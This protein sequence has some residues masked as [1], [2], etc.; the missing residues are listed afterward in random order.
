MNKLARLLALSSVI[1]ITPTSWSADMTKE[2]DRKH[3]ACLERIAVDADLAYEEAMIWRDDGGG[4]R[5]KHCVAMSLFALGHTEEAAH[6]LDTLA[7]APD[8][9]TEEMRISFYAEAANF[10]L[11]AENPKKA[12]ESATA[13]LDM[14]KK[15][16]ALR[17]ARARAYAL[18]ERYD[19]A[20][21]DL[22]SVLT[23]EPGHAEAH[24]FRANARLEQG[25]LEGALEDIEKS[26]HANPNSMETALLRGRIREAIRVSS[27]S[28]DTEKE[29][30]Q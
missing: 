24:R 10:W 26:L 12:Y 2:F 9:G 25:N 30:S 21:V 16:L 1:A 11:M 27:Q 8:G 15:D 19:Y 20:E 17:I 5:A 29:T 14:D 3:E 28:Q 22:T 13:G 18:F 4:R 6:R 7:Q 23:L